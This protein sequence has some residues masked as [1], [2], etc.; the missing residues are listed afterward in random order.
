MAITSEFKTL[1]LND[2]LEKTE[3]KG[4]NL[5]FLTDLSK[6]QLISL[7]KAAEIFEPFHKTLHNVFPAKYKNQ[8]FN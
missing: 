1:K 4:K 7:F 5:N 3:L 2:Y 6:E 8:V